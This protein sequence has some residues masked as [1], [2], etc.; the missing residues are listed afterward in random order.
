[1]TNHCGGVSLPMIAASLIAGRCCEQS[2]HSK[3]LAAFDVHAFHSFVI[4]V[5]QESGSGFEHV[6]L[7]A[8]KVMLRLMMFELEATIEG[9]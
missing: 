4:V 6:S 8:F 3:C 9:L 5:H 2:A 7:G 1:M